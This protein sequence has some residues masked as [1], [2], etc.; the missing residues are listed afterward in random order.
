MAEQEKHSGTSQPSALP[1]FLLNES[2]ESQRQVS[3]GAGWEVYEIP[4]TFQ[5][6]CSVPLVPQPNHFLP[7]RR[8]PLEFH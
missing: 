4:A 1:L 7:A 8:L 2:H 5:G 3:A 6:Q